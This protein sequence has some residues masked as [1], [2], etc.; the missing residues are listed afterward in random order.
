M[1][2]RLIIGSVALVLAPMVFA[3]T[4][5]VEARR[6]VRFLRHG[7]VAEGE[8]IGEELHGLQFR[9]PYP[10]VQFRVKDGSIRT[11]RSRISRRSRGFIHP[12]KVVVRYL[13]D[14]PDEAELFSG[15]HPYK[16]LAGIS[17]VLALTVAFAAFGLPLFFVS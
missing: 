2:T 10:V 12:E 8:V 13:A 14:S 7:V 3:V 5:V 15:F 1:D 16:H 17:L 6:V 11:F 9:A 4:T